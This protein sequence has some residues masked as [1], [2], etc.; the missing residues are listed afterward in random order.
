VLTLIA[1]EALKLRTI[2][3]P[4]LV[5]LGAQVVVLL[6]VAGRTVNGDA[7]DPTLAIGA[8][9]HVGLVSLFALVLGIMIAALEYRHRT[10]TDTYLATPRRS[11][12]I[13]AKVAVGVASGAALGIVSCV[14]AVTGTAVAAAAKGATVD[15]SDAELWRTL[16]GG[17]VWNT[18]FAAIGIGIGALVR[19]LAAA[20]AAT[21]AWL[22]LVEGVV[23]QLVGDQ[24]ARWLPFAAGMAL[25]RSPTAESGLS[26]WGAALVLTAYAAVAAVLAARA[27]IRRDI[28]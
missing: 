28:A 10:A 27:T 11:R 9:A 24:V 12:V 22:A 25:G 3:S 2:R 23:S 20:V 19:N 1:N 15:W 7:D 13:A 16:A 26:Q 4:W 8:V 14:T 6:G 21:L 18:A 5:A 17:L